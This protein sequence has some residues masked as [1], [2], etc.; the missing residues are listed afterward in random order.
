MISF[1]KNE[2]P[3]P[4]TMVTQKEIIKQKKYN[5]ANDINAFENRIRAPGQ[6][7]IARN[8]HKKKT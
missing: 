8:A 2:L 3:L 4:I 7:T 1:K 5:N 6:T